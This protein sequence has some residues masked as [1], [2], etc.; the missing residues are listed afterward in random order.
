WVVPR[1][2]GDGER[3][4]PIQL[5]T[6]EVQ[7]NINDQ[8][9]TSRIE[10]VFHNPSRQRL[11]ATYYFPIPANAH[12]DRFSM[13]I[14]GSEVEGELLD[15]AKARDIYERIVR[16]MKDPALLEFMDHGL[17]RVRIFPFEPQSERRIRLQ[18]TQLL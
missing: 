1:T 15:A 8:I 10:Q 14:D 3:L 2:P 12:I 13:F 6:Q 5:R 17:F 9:A 18:Y 11:E 7:T 4:G 16:Q